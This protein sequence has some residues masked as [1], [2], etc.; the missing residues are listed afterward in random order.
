MK[1]VPSW[2][3]KMKYFSAVSRSLIII[4]S[5]DKKKLLFCDLGP[6]LSLSHHTQKL[7]DETYTVT[8][9]L[10]LLLLVFFIFFWCLMW[11]IILSTTIKPNTI[12]CTICEKTFLLPFFCCWFSSYLSYSIFI[13]S[14]YLTTTTNRREHEE[15]KKFSILIFATTKITFSR[16]SRDGI[17]T[18]NGRK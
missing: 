2:K 18:G 4:T 15:K 5:N 17:E 1:I 9:L 3:Q 7:Y 16:F 11:A 8:L 10:L 12:L 13:L 6:S 14:S